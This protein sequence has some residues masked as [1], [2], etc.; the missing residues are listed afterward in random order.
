VLTDYE[1]QLALFKRD[2]FLC[3]TLLRQHSERAHRFAR[4]SPT[5]R[6]CARS[7]TSAAT[8]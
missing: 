2:A 5:T 8:T 1:F 3:R 6:S 7:P 4:T